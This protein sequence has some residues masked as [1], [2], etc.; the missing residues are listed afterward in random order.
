MKYIAIKKDKIGNGE[1]I[2]IRVC[3]KV[4]SEYWRNENYKIIE[5]KENESYN[6]N[7]VSQWLSSC[8]NEYESF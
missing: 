5:L 1:N 7:I 2:D 6:I 8:E 3:N 4:E